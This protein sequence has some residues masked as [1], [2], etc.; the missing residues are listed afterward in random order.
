MSENTKTNVTENNAQGSTVEAFKIVI[1]EH[2][3]FDPLV[4]T[5]FVTSTEFCKVVSD[6]FRAV[7]PDCV[8]SSLDMIPAT[9][10][11]SISLYFDHLD[12]GDQQT[13]V[14][15]DAGDQKTKNSVLKSTRN[16]YT[17][18]RVGDKYLLTEDGKSAIM[19]FLMD[20]EVARAI[21]NN[22]FEVK[23]DKITTDVADPSAGMSGRQLTKVSF[24]DPNKLAAAIYGDKNF[25]NDKVVYN[26]R[27]LGSL[28]VY[29]GGY[30]SAGYSLAVDR[31]TEANV[32]KMSAAYGIGANNGLNIIR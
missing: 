2:E 5:S 31:V 25:N 13:A 19:D 23:W 1:D 32:H 9:N 16:Y 7:F 29:V 11:Q 27:N 28:P 6:L 18:L 12:H 3:K 24:I 22:N 21:Y 8:G 14:S 17:R 15:R 30:S 20:P 26:I 10:V 4:E